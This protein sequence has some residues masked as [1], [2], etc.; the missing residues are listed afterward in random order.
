MSFSLE[1]AVGDVGELACV[2]KCYTTGF[3]QVL[4]GE[5]AATDDPSSEIS[6]ALGIGAGEATTVVVIDRA[7]G[8]FVLGL[9]VED[10][11]DA[12]F[13][14]AVIR[15]EQVL[16]LVAGPRFVGHCFLPFHAINITC[17]RVVNRSHAHFTS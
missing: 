10:G 1:F 12:T 4:A 17:S 5:G 13:D 3:F 11:D 14:G 7:L 15:T 6:P 8:L 9:T 16:D 2:K